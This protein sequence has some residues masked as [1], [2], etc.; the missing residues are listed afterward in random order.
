M[1]HSDSDAAPNHYD[2]PGM[3]FMETALYQQPAAYAEITGNPG[4][5]DIIGIVRFY[6]IDKGVLV[7]AEVY[8]LPVD[9]ASCA[10]NIHGFHIHQGNSCTGNASDPYANAGT[11]YNPGNCPHPSHAGDMPPL[12]SNNGFAWMM[13]VTNHVSISEIIGKTVIIHA[14]PD[15]FH[16]Q[17][18]GD[19]GAKIAC[20]TIQAVGSMN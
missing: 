17:P 1:I 18:S 6:S 8:G 14:M 11:H 3:Q 13:F 5:G 16:S 2:N 15:D 12:F 10:S 19:S 4:N 9:S 7:N 20:G